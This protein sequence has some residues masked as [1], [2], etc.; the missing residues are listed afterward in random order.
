MTKRNSE[1][2]RMLSELLETASGLNKYGVLSKTDMAKMK[3]LC[4]PPPEYTP[5]RVIAIRTGIAKMS[6]AV[7]AS[8]LNVSVS[9]VQKWESSVAHKHPGGAAAKLLQL[10]ES[11]GVDALVAS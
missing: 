7:F 11:K 9:T 3:M 6:Q 4:E 1:E 8:V 5:D 10:V 2:S